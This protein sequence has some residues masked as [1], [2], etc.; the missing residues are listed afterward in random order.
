[1]AGN[2]IASGTL[3]SLQFNSRGK[4]ADDSGTLPEGYDASSTEPG[5]EAVGKPGIGTERTIEE[6][7]I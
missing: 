6:V 1:M 2:T 5:D 4:S 3:G 7:S